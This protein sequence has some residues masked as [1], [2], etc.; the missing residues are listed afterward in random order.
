MKHFDLLEGRH[1]VRKYSDK[2]PPKE[3]VEKS[4]WKAWK[5]TPTKNNAMPYKVFVYGPEKKAEKIKVWH[6][7][8]KN[9][10]DAEKRA[11]LRR[12]AIKTEGGFPN[13]FYEHIKFNPYLFTIHSQPREP[14]A[15]Y[16][17]Q[18]K[19]GMFYDQSH[20]DRIEKFIDTCAV[21]VGMFIQNLSS[22]LLEEG[23]DVS[24]TSCFYRSAEKW[25]DV[26]LKHVEYR[27]II[28]MSAGYGEVYRKQSLR[29]W[30]RE[31]EDIKP[32]YEEMIEWL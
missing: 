25:R 30:G 13:P 32:E 27:P 2:V 5:T 12:Q 19:L 16:K 31:K 6:M 23:I 22:Y 1:H 10:A 11:L 4:L 24:F 28:L 26:G 29:A 8:W 3:L 7:V 14:N 20:P 17:K 9:H 15:F 21:E 18:I